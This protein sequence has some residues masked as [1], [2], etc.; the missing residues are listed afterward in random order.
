MTLQDALKRVASI[1]DGLDV[2][3]KLSNVGGDTAHAALAAISKLIEVMRTGT[4]V[5]IDAAIAK[6]RKDVASNDRAADSAI[7]KKFG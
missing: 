2:I 4:H 7:D 5:E 3:Q 6:L 1:V